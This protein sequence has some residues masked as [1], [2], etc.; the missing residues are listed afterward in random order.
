MTDE[1]YSTIILREQKKLSNKRQRIFNR[2]KNPFK[3]MPAADAA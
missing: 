2:S 1:F 3:T